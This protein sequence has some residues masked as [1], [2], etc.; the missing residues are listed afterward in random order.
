[1]LNKDLEKRV[2]DGIEALN[3]NEKLLIQQSKMAAMGEMIGNIA[4]QWRQ[5]LNIISSY[6]MRIENRYYDDALNDDFVDEISEKVN[7]TLQYMS[8]TIDDFRNFFKPSK[9]KVKFNIYK[10]IQAIVSITLEQL[11]NNDIK[12]NID[13]EDKAISAYSYENEFKQVIIN[14]VNNAKDAILKRRESKEIDNGSIDIKV[15]QED[16]YAVVKIEDNG[17]GI[18]GDIIDKVFDPYFTTKFEAQ[19]T[20]L[21]LYMS[22]TIIEKNM[23]G[24]LTVSNSDTGA[25][26][27]I[28]IRVKEV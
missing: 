3:K 20:G 16:E 28:K 12:L 11:K 25:C 18:P 10:S 21:G 1:M 24:L 27:V 22:K 14:I 8:K 7:S 17:G 4:H 15:Y 13:V 5:P 19:G 9:E 6:M 2:E 26:F 23:G